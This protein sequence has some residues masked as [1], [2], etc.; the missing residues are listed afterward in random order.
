METFDLTR[1]AYSCIGIAGRAADVLRSEIGAAC[2]QYRIEDDY[3]RG[4]LEDLEEI[5]ADPEDYLDWWN[6]LEETDVG[7]FMRD[8]DAL[9]GHIKRTLAIPIEKRGTPP[10]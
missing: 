4:I 9:R 7:T 8:L 10:G 6:L 2:S 5:A 3:L 1:M